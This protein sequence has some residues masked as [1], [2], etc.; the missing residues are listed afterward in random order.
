MV[1]R[2][3]TLTFDELLA[4]PLVEHTT[5]LTCVSNEVG[6]DLVGNASWLGLPIRELLAEAGPKPGADMVLSSSRDGLTAGTPLDVLLE[7]ER[8]SLL[9]V[10]MNGEPLPVEHGFPVRMVVPGLYGYVSATKWV[11]ELKLTTLR[12]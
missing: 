10:G 2:E 1:E 11:V 7:P 5:T 9:A 12:G 6:G 3:L 8:A 4:R